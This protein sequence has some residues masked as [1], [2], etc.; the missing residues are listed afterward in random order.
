MFDAFKDMAK[1]PQMLQ[2][3]KAAQEKM[4]AMQES[5]ARRQFSGTDDGGLV[6]ATVSGTLEVIDVQIRTDAAGRDALQPAIVEACRNAQQQAQAAIR[7]EMRRVAEDAGLPADAL[8][9]QM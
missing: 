1:L 6:S 7:H 5:M 9:G 2:Q 4:R 8:P 3:A